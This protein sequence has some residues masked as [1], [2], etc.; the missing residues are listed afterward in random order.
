[1]VSTYS[2]KEA[3]TMNNESC[4]ACGRPASGP[5]KV[6]SGDTT[7]SRVLCNACYNATIAKALGLKHF[8]NAKFDPMDLMATDGT[9]HTFHFRYRLFATG[10]VLDAFELDDG[11]PSGQQFR[12]MGEPDEDPFELLGRLVKK[13]RQALSTHHLTEGEN[14]RQIAN[15]GVVRGN[16]ECD[17]NDP[18]RRMP[19][20]VIDGEEITWEEFGQMLTSYEGWRFKLKLLEND[21]D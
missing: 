12:V 3:T 18:Y 16:I 1:M 9:N 6:V 11:S 10:V 17:M 20:L 13:M 14:G 7:Q 15:H 21:E 4:D 5:D 2:C 19:L 8:E